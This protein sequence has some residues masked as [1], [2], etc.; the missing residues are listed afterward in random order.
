MLA[1]A[2]QMADGYPIE[3]QLANGLERQKKVLS[4]LAVL[5][6][7]VPAP[8]R[9]GA[10]GAGQPARSSCRRTSRPRCAS[11]S[12]P[13]SQALAAGQEPAR[14]ADG[15]LRPLLQ[16][17]HR[18]RAGAR[19]RSEQGGLITKED[20]AR[21]RPRLEEPVKTSY[22]GIDVYKLTVWTQGPAMLQALNLLEGT[23]LQG[24]GLQ[25]AALHPHPVPGDQHGLRRPRL[26]L[27][28]PDLPAGGAG[29]GAALE[30]VR[31]QALGRHARRPQRS[32]RAPRRSLSRSRAATNPFQ[33]LLD[34]WRSVPGPGHGPARARPPRAGS[35]SRPRERRGHDLGDRG[36]RRRLGGV[37]DAER[38]LEPGGRRRPDRH[39]AQPAHAGVRGRAGRQPLQRGRAR[40]AAAGHA[41][42]DADA[43]GRAAPPRLGGPGR[44]H[45][46]PEPAAVLPERGRVRDERAAGDRGRRTSTATSSAAPSA[47]TSRGPAT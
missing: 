11:W 29:G 24:D 6:G 38:R 15:R 47:P 19:R 40:Q 4:G 26:L 35:A 37:D 10:R 1:P 32:G 17:R 22:K 13:S 41:H 7:G 9:A 34:A 31:P 43:E 3:A 21:W 46:G 42:A 39:R 2:I 27:R 30:G 18:G 14:G 25:L 45:A 44:R 5:E 12:R 33:A 23:D 8:P 28:R 36:G 20:L 16:G